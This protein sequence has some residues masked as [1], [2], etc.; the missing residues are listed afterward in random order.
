MQ[1]QRTLARIT[2]FGAALLFVL[3]LPQTSRAQSKDRV[4]V[5]ERLQGDVSIV[6]YAFNGDR[7]CAS[8]RTDTMCQ[9]PTYAVQQIWSLLDQLVGSG[10]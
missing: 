5:V 10:G 7:L 9:E 3:V 2:L 6:R 4:G 1:C 8:Q